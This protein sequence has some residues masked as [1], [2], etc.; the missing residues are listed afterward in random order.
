HRGLPARQVLR[1]TQ[2]RAARLPSPRPGRAG[3]RQ[4]PL[5]A[6][7]DGAVAHDDRRR[8]CQLLHRGVRVTGERGMNLVLPR[9][10]LARLNWPRVTLRPDVG[11]LA[12]KVVIVTLFSSM[13]M[14]LARDAAATGHVTGMLLVASEA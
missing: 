10:H 11:E 14:R 8:L 13:A 3:D 5:P 12:A 9:A 2:A 7:R 6:A 4:V 1:A